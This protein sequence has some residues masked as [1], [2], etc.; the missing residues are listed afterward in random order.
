MQRFMN[1]LR[2]P[3]HVFRS[4]LDRLQRLYELKAPLN[5]VGDAALLLTRGIKPAPLHI[6]TW[7]WLVQNSPDWIHC[8]FSPS[9]R[10]MKQEV[11]QMETLIDDSGILDNK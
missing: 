7:T 3:D 8:I 4:R 11:D 9:F 1:E 6:K 10:K 2:V 5:V